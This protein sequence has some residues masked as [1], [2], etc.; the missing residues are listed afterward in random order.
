MKW[1]DWGQLTLN[2]KKLEYACFGP[3]PHQARTF[4]LL[5]EGLGCIDLWRDFPKKLAAATGWG[6]LAYSRAG[7]GR[8]DAEQ[9]P[10]P[11]DY[12]ERHA[13]HVLPDI[14]AGLGDHIIL[15]HSDGASIAAVHAGRV[16]D[17]RLL[18]TILIAPHFFTEAL[19][20]TEITR[21]RE[22]YETGD[23][24]SRLAKYHTHVECAFRGWCDSWLAPDFKHWSI[25][26]SLGAVTCPVLALQ[27]SDDR[28]GTLAQIDVLQAECK[29]FVIRSVL[30]A[31]GHS[32]HLDNSDEVL[33]QITRF[34]DQF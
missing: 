33:A 10:W 16:S 31:V 4:V 27:G 23:L 6:V 1:V 29:A 12:M 9:L 5:H 18:G 25:V 2:G 15:G 24:R 34:L 21:A 28:F 11:L 8:S 17:R 20:L 3:P 26:D 14:L 22:A 30:P 7:Y 19:C 13:A 32:P